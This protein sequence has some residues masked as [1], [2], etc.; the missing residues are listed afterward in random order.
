MSPVIFVAGILGALFLVKVAAFVVQLNQGVKVKSKLGFA[1]YMF[2]W[3]GV[4]YQGF[5]KRLK[6]PVKETGKYFLES[7]LIMLAGF[8]LLFLSAWYGEGK[9]EP[10]NYLA[11][12]SLLMIIH[13]G[14]LEALTDGFRLMGLSPRSLFY[15]PYLAE[16]FRDFWSNR[17]NR[18]FVDM[19]KLF[20]LAP[21]KGKLPNAV[22][23]LAIFI[24]SGIVHELAIS[25]PA[26]GPWG[27][28]LLYFLFQ[29]AGVLLERYIKVPRVVVIAWIFLPLP[30][31]F[32]PQFVN[33]YLG[34]LN[35][36]IFQ[37]I[38][39]RPWQDYLHYG[40]LLGAFFHLLVLSISV[41]VA[42]KLNW[43]EEF[44]RLS[45]L[46][47][48]VFWTYGGYIFTIIIFLG[49]VSWYL[50]I[51]GKYSKGDLLWSFFISLFWWGRIV[52]DFF[53]YGHEDWP[54]GPLFTIGH[55]M[56]ST[57]F[58]SMVGLYSFLTLLMTFGM[59]W[60]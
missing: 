14:L 59:I 57:L 40:F 39:S 10:H 24:F 50:S 19:D 31:L 34:A 43:K 17:W 48:K 21:L 5:E 53:Y 12:V 8:V 13:M 30:V 28:P 20:V 45:N 55:I 22:L 51:P 15:R 37:N 1:A 38:I 33:L 3:P 16:S 47:R 7:W 52:V 42:G 25:L 18:A 4:S 46:N 26:G 27:L 11:L 41:Q 49:L 44:K 32:P 23:I 54:K 9:S 35:S 2:M 6:E 36:F 58:I 29:A 60:Q 56:S